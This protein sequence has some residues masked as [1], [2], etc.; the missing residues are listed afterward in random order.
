MDL[1]GPLLLLTA[2]LFLL[3]LRGHRAARGNLPP[4]PRPLPLLGNLRQLWGPSLLHSLLALRDQYGPVFTI[5][6]GPHRA[7]VLWGYEAVKE[8]LV[9]H[10]EEFSG[11]EGLALAERTSK[12]N[13]LF[14]SNGETWQ[15]LRRFAL[16]TL[17]DFGMG[18]RSIEERIREEAHYLLEELGK[19]K[20]IPID[21]TFVLRRS[22]SNVI[23]SVVFGARFDYA[24]QEFQTLLSLIQANFRRVDTVW[25]QLYNLFPTIMNLLPGPHHRL[26]ENFEEQKRYVAGVVQKHRETLDPSSPRDY[27]DAFLI[28]MQQ[29]ENDPD[30]K[31]HQDN[32][33][34]SALDLFFGGTETTSTTLRYGLLLLLKHP[35]VAAQV[36]AEIEREI[37]QQ[38]APRMEDRAKMPYTDAVIHEIQRFADVLPLGV[39]HAVTRDTQFRGY[40][41]PKVHW[42]GPHNVTPRRDTGHP[43]QRLHP[44]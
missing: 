11:R 41:L 44:S 8:A 3:L 38:R 20:G 19:T 37:G 18:K 24:D 40:A 32:L 23:C 27:T 16:S 26:F 29:E 25:V 9:D 1:T 2:V 35:Q 17:R 39:P 14:F 31:F 36:Q 4:G 21:P 30:T 12:G 7:V 13:G 15:Q 6:M 5:Y 22:V 33:L 34:L 10:A 28:R 43:V 42:A